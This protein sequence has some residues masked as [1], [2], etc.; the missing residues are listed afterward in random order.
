MRRALTAALLALLLVA[1]AATA[2][3]ARVD[4]DAALAGLGDVKKAADEVWNKIKTIASWASTIKNNVGDGLS[5]KLGDLDKAKDKLNGLP[6]AMAAVN[7]HIRESDV[8]EAFKS[9][10]NGVVDAFGGVVAQFDKIGDDVAALSKK[11][12]ERAAKFEDE[13]KKVRASAREWM[14]ALQG[15]CKTGNPNPFLDD[16][17]A[18]GNFSLPDSFHCTF[19]KIT[20]NWDLPKK[21]ASNSRFMELRN[22]T[23]QQ[24]CKRIKLFAGI[25]DQ[26]GGFL[27][28]FLAACDDPSPANPPAFFFSRGWQTLIFASSE[29]AFLTSMGLRATCIGL[30]LAD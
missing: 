30:L 28:Q 24:Q 5:D 9:A 29:V 8:A 1:A 21:V 22:D 17:K 3:D 25:L 4:A 16:L 6:D 15:K 11:L 13:L 20:E 14:D 7:K 27:V 2:L 19:S 12:D 26:V 23:P 18:F 10:S